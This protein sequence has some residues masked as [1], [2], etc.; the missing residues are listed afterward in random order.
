MDTVERDRQGLEPI[1]DAIDRIAA[2][3]S[4]DAYHA[5]LERAPFDGVGGTLPLSVFPDLNESTTNA[6]YLGGPTLGLPNRDYY[7]DDE[8]SLVPVREA[9]VE[10][11]AALLTAAAYTADEAREV[12]QAV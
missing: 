2:I 7:L 1:R 10:T 4:E 8:P 12:A 6:L 9:Y 11:G 3:D 5:Y